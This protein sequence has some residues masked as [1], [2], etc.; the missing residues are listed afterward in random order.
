M[1][2][3][4]LYLFPDTNI[5]VQCKPLEQLDWSE[6]QDFAEIRLL[7]CR[8][9]Q[10]E[11]DDQKT[12]GNSRVASRARATYQLFRKIIDGRKECELISS[13]SPV[14]KLY[15]QGP[16][17]PSL[18]LEDTLDYS[19]PDDQI[20]GH[21]H[22]F[23]QD[24]QGVDARLLTYDGGPMMT[25]NSLGI[26]YIAI[27]D[28]WLLAPENNELERENA[29]LRER[30]A[31]LENTEPK[32]K[33]WLV[34]DSGTEVQ[35][36][37][38][39]HHVYEP[40]SGEEVDACI[41][42]LK[43]EFPLATDFGSREPEVRDGGFV[44]GGFLKQIY[45]PATDEAIAKYRDQDYPKWIEECKE[46]LLDLH[47]TLQTEIPQPC[48]S[49]VATNE[50]TRPG[51]D[52]LINII[53]KGNL[54]ICPPPARIDDETQEEDN[55]APTLPSPPNPPTGTWR[56]SAPSWDQ[57]NAA[58]SAFQNVFSRF[59]D[60]QILRIHAP[61]VALPGGAN[62][63]R[64][65]NRFYYKPNR[66]WT[67]VESYSLEYEQWRHGSGEEYFDGRLF[68][69]LDEEK[70]RGSL[71]CEIHAENLSTPVRK[72]VPVNISIKRSKT[73]EYARSLI[74]GLPRFTN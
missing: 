21:L 17:Q 60:P 28:D 48:F 54:K 10:R 15:L 25:A 68:F 66:P 62:R 70:V 64:D 52:A 27:K 14:V 19:K 1:S 56:F 37:E 13:A 43:S 35:S 30:V 32:F 40:I 2:E 31:Q 45:T 39:E 16:S 74:Q 9:V 57:I 61:P 38:V 53:S 51:N 29:R 58:Q 33:I 59:R 22:K 44:A 34:N 73:V 7:V 49:F 3:R 47:E 72:V 8:P 55:D 41:Q 12:R 4:I 23:R 26:P 69:D 71:S 6:W 46:F 11:I 63:R 5:F 24:H 18:D 50:G 36:V 42:L 67:P 20:I 65:P